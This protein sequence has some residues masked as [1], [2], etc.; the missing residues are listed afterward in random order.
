MI[1]LGVHFFVFILFGDFWTSWVCC[2][3]LILGNSESSLLHL[4]TVLKSLFSF[5]CSHCVCC[6][7]VIVPKFLGF[8]PIFFV[9]FI[10]VHLFW[11]VV[12]SFPPA[13]WFLPHM[14]PLY[15]WAA[16]APAP[17]RGILHL[18][19]V[20]LTSFFLPS[21]LPSWFYL[22]F[23]FRERGREG[24][25]KGKEKT[26][27]CERNIGCL[28]HAPNRCPDQE[29]TSDLCL[30][31]DTK[32]TEPHHSGLNNFCFRFSFPFCDFLGFP[33]LLTWPVCSHMLST[34][35][36]RVLAH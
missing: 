11:K 22:L 32:P 4:F 3:S 33:S 7:F 12:F 9:L 36:I 29:S 17:P 34:T 25:L 28:S 6:T 27:M 35:S 23:V 31:Q 16:A 13:H 10:F 20:V 2:L 14:F 26:S 19:S 24:S 5:M 30:P 18:C 21:T 8:C 1:F 15:R